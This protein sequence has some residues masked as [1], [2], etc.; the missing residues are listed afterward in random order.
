MKRKWRVR[1]RCT[2]WGECA[3]RRRRGCSA[4]RDG[5][6]P[7]AS[8][9]EGRGGRVPNPPVVVAGRAIRAGSCFLGFLGA[10]R[11]GRDLAFFA[12]EHL[13]ASLGL[14]EL[15]AAGIA[16]AHAAFKQLEGALEREVAGFELLDDLLELVE[17]SFEGLGR[18]GIG[19]VFRHR[20]ILL[21]E[22][23]A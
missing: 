9:P 4:W 21:R 15:L 8:F 12:D 23:E 3:C 14:L 13:D 2:G 5:W 1:L 11:L 17:R 16:E 7:G 6:F 19:L 20:S 22:G 10:E 18:P